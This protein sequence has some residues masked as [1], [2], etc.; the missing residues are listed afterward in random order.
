MGSLSVVKVEP[1]FIAQFLRIDAA[2]AVRVPSFSNVLSRGFFVLLSKVVLEVFFSKDFSSD[3]AG[4]GEPDEKHF[5][6]NDDGDDED[7][8]VG[9]GE[10]D[11]QGG[12]DL[13][14][15]VH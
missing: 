14:Q 7:V 2:A 13:V 9:V 8:A 10:S 6:C 5:E 1:L 12:G 11:G 4:E 3:F 15:F